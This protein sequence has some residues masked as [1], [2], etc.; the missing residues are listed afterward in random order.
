MKKLLY[1]VS[2]ALIMAS[3]VGGNTTKNNANSACSSECGS[4]CESSTKTADVKSY[5][6]EE[7]LM[8]AEGLVDTEVVVVGTITHTCKHSGRRCF[9]VGDDQ[10]TSFRI[11]AKGDI[12]GFN[13]ELIGSELAVKGMLRENRLTNEYL[14]AWEEKVVEKQGKEDGSAESCGSETANINSMR[15]WMKKNNKEYYSLYF[16]DGTSFEVVE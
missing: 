11:E 16:M 5:K 13:R 7:L 15:E 9:M 8:A 3:C 2:A 12:G 4:S 1:A 14:D 10:K 6:L